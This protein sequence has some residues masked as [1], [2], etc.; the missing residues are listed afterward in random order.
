MK[1]IRFHEFGTVEVLRFE[2][3]LKPAFGPNEVLVQLKAAALNH[4]DIWVRSGSRERNI[5]L[6][7]IPGSDGAGI[8]AEVGSAVDFLKVGDR[9]LI[10]PGI[11]CGHCEMCL[12]GTDN[13]CRAYHVL[14]T[15]EDG[16]YA[17]F[18]KLPA[19]NVLPIPEG[20]DFNQAAAIPLVFLTAW[21]MLVGVVK[22]K[23]GETVLVHGGG[24]GV[25]SAGIQIAKLFGAHVII[26]AGSDEKLNKAK[27]LGADEGINYKEKDFVEEVKQITSKRGVD[28][29]F[30]HT[31][32]EIFEKSIPTLAKG[33][34]LVTC[35]STDNYLAKVDI[36]YVFAKHL[37]IFGSF[38]GTKREMIEVLKF[39]RKGIGCRQLQPVMDSVFPLERA[40]EAHKRM[41]ERKN[42][43][44][45]VLSI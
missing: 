25:G 11:S 24:S 34:R 21:H 4:L 18:V 23:P 27:E 1:A 10:S 5:P 6:P 44:K 41:E 29:V 15:K 42:F 14:G 39:F 26:T 3:V 38:M 12:G 22:I 20:L 28:I 30:E 9:V 36:R 31:G 45:I 33:G 19:D 2:D 40:A 7:H 43:G 8:I 13:L 16:T 32:G 35:G 37:T 17:E